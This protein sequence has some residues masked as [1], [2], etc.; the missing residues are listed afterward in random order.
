MLAGG[1]DL[2]VEVPPTSL[3]QFTDTDAYQVYEQSGPHVWFLIL[4]A[5]EGPFAD[6][7]VRQAVNY[8]VDKEAIVNDMLEGTA[9]VAAGRG[10]VAG[11]RCTIAAPVA[12]AVAADPAASRDPSPT[13]DATARTAVRARPNAAGNIARAFFSSSSSSKHARVVVGVED[14]LARIASFFRKSAAVAPPS[15]ARIAIARIARSLANAS[16]VSSSSSSRIARDIDR[17]STCPVPVRHSFA[18]DIHS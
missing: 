10:T 1:I 12:R 2:M 6:K 4:N 8:A 18:R 14:S 15:F 17:A 13:P 11:Y 5:K 9:E 16:N 7:R 3:G